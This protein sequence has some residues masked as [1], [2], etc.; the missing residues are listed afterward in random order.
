MTLRTVLRDSELSE[1]MKVFYL[2]KVNKSSGFGINISEVKFLE[3]TE[4]MRRKIKSIISSHISL[5]LNNKTEVSYNIDDAESNI[6]YFSL[7]VESI[8]NFNKIISSINNLQ[9]NRIN[10]LFSSNIQNLNPNM[11]IIKVTLNGM[12]Y[13]FF[14]NYNAAT[15][16]K[17]T[18]FLNL[19]Q[20]D[21]DSS[22]FI[23]IKNSIDSVYDSSNNMMYIMK[24]SNFET[25][26]NYKDD[27]RA[28][29]E[30]LLEQIG[31]SNFVVDYEYFKNEC[32]RLETR[33]K[34]LARIFNEDKFQR[35]LIN[36]SNIQNVI[37]GFNLSVNL[38]NNNQVVIYPEMGSAEEKRKKIEDLLNLLDL[39]QW[40]NAITR[41]RAQQAIPQYNQLRLL[42]TN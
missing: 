37:T 13:F 3:I 24:K 17:K 7:S 9:N 23:T 36:R 21:I 30:S 12:D 38:N 42:A 39:S 5:I 28:R 31:N 40:E 1:N 32:L 2:R 41:E 10:Q 19:E 22:G 4:G 35:L 29:A 34:K 6:H 26:F 25:I 33:V 15:L 11:Y 16:L 20:E 14:K 18:T 27:Y 8:S